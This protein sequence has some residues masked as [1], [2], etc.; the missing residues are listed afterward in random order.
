MRGDS[1]MDKSSGA[2]LHQKDCV[3]PRVDVSRK[4]WST[5]NTLSVVF[6]ALGLVSTLLS[7]ARCE[8]IQF[9]GV[10]AVGQ[11]LLISPYL[12][13]LGAVGLGWRGRLASQVFAV[14]AA[15]LA[16]VSLFEL[17]MPIDSSPQTPREIWAGMRLVTVALVQLF[18]ALIFCMI[19]L[20][21]RLQDP[22]PST[23]APLTHV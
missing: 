23:Q 14:G 20:G 21:V 11:I 13:L 16:V 8:S 7:I 2:R 19:G 12:I 4:T 18:P 22:K 1:G 3:I 17:A 6:V 10:S 9:G 5:A 15:I